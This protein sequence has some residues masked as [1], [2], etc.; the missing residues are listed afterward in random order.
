MRAC[1]SSGRRGGGPR[2]TTSTST[3][4]VRGSSASRQCSGAPSPVISP[5]RTSSFLLRQDARPEV[6][7]RPDMRAARKRSV[8]HFLG[9]DIRGK[10]PEELEY[11]KKFDAWIVGSYAA[12]RW[13]PD[14]VVIPARPRPP[15]TTSPSRRSS[16]SV[17]SSCTHRR[18]SRRRARATSSRRAEQLPVDLDVVHGVPHDEAGRA[19]QAGRH[20]RRP[21]ALPLARRL[22]DRVDGVRQAGRSLT[23]TRRPWRRRRRPFGLK[24]PI[25]TA[26]KGR[27]RGEATAARRARSSCRKRLGEEGRAYVERVHDLDKGRRPF[28]RNLR[29]HTLI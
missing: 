13:V 8:M 24:V 18:I 25:V 14:A 17:R 16:A 11:R 22:R 2:N 4:R 9:D 1:S 12:T 7:E 15:R 10:R 6:A 5:K 27:P 19:L 21:D 26:T 20:R 28:H 3:C 23:S 29:L